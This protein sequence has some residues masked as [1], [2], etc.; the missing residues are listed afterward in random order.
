[1]K[2]GALRAS[3]PELRRHRVFG[4]RR[5]QNYIFLGY[6]LNRE[7]LRLR[8]VGSPKEVEMQYYEKCVESQLKE[9]Q[10]R[11]AMAR[12]I[13]DDIVVNERR[14]NAAVVTIAVVTGLLAIIHN[15]AA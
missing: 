4:A 12:A 13:I 8:V 5:G 9:V 1:M 3:F 7:I 11:Q 15:L 6:M 2:S 14:F 10:N